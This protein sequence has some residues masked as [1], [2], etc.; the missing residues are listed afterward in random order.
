VSD[1]AAG[2]TTTAVLAGLAVICVGLQF[3][4]SLWLSLVALVLWLLGTAALARPVL[5]R[6]WRPRF[7]ALSIVIA[8]GSGLLLG[9]RDTVLLGLRVSSKGLRAG[10]LMVVRGTLILGLTAW[11]ATLL[12]ARRGRPGRDGAAVGAL[13]T[14]V[15]A[16][17]QLVPELSERVREDWIG[18]VRA[19][20]GR[21]AALR[22][23]GANLV[24]HATCVAEEMVRRERR[25]P[26][27]HAERAR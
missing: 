18:S 8:L 7:L 2:R 20:G 12:M 17:V 1:T 5:A 19:G 23:A 27:P 15:A 24:Y 4:G 22:S 21:L 13:G 14:A 6:L 10:G 11:A 25:A 26:D 16:A 9:E 3:P